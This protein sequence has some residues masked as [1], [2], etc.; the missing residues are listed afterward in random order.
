MTTVGLITT[1]ECEHRALAASLGR[2]A[3]HR[4]HRHVQELSRRCSFHLLCPMLESY[5]FGEPAA[6]ARAGAARPALLSASRHL[7]AFESADLASSTLTICASTGGA[8][9]SGSGTPSS[10]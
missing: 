3:T 7:E 5:F 6:L 1:G 8:A 9:R 10:T 2:A 4:E